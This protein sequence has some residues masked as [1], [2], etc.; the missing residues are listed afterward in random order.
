MYNAD[1]IIHQTSGVVVEE[2]FNTKVVDVI[3]QKM[4]NAS[5]PQLWRTYDMILTPCRLYAP[6]GWCSY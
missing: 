1:R 5:Q 3:R 6:L 2:Q 4:L